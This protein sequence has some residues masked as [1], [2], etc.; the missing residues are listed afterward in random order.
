MLRNIAP[1]LVRNGHLDLWKRREGRVVILSILGYGTDDDDGSE[2]GRVPLYHERQW[3]E[4]IRAAIGSCRGHIDIVTF[5]S[6]PPGVTMS[7]RYT[8]RR[9]SAAAP[10]TTT[11]LP[12]C[13]LRWGPDG[14]G[15][16][17]GF[18]GGNAYDSI[19]VIG[20]SIVPPLDM[21]SGQRRGERGTRK[22]GFDS[23]HR[24]DGDARWESPGIRAV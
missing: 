24:H 16:A 3:K 5:Y 11:S 23:S 4:Q 18:P 9:P 1:R 21:S 14:C 12:V 2:K 22:G 15:L 17:I 19:S 13:L 6:R 8:H 10:T 7:M 20:K